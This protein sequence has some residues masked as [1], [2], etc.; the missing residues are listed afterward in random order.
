MI[1]G[2]A[3]DLNLAN[4]IA[5]NR[6]RAVLLVTAIGGASGVLVALLSL[7]VVAAIVALI[8]GVVV[9]AAVAAAAWWGSEPLAR[10]RIDAKPADPFHDARLI[11]LVEGLCLTA[12][13]P[14]PRLYVAGDNGL[15]A[16]TLGR[17]PRRASLVVTR[18]LLDTLSR[19]EL[20]AVLAHEL[21]HIKS[22]DTL[23]ATVAV[24]V[25][26]F[27]VVPARDASFGTG[28]R[29]A[30]GYALLPASALA[31]LGLQR[32][33]GG[34]REEIADLSGVSLTR[35]PPALIAALEKL[36]GAGT[37]IASGSPA[38]A[39]LW[40]GPPEPPTRPFRAAWLGRLFETH[41]PLD[42]RIEALR[43]L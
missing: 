43:E 36:Q 27:L 32:S 33:V 29:A 21:S 20:E 25:V 13:L 8:I 14:A 11:N 19:I 16:L 2:V 28:L 23:P 41:P 35:Y 10:R 9:G 34:Q 26:G 37:V 5:A 42:D 40:L 18:G 30:V 12:G 22:Y 1:A 15:N 4:R 38:V 7:L 17:D 31:G 6:R 3:G 39:H 24:A